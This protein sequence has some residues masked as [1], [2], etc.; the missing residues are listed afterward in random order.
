MKTE[1][2]QFNKTVRPNR[3]RFKKG[4]SSY[5]IL[6]RDLLLITR[7]FYYTEVKRL[8]FD[9]ALETLSEEEFFIEQTT[10]LNRLNANNEEFKRRFA[11]KPTLARLREMCGKFKVETSLEEKKHYEKGLVNNQ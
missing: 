11:N 7:Y 6:K 1:N 2:K 8:R 10:I 3:N 5:L 4:R 9:D